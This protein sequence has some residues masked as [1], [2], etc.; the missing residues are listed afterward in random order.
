KKTVFKN[1]SLVFMGFGLLFFGM[2]LISIS[3]HHFAENP[4]LTEVFQSLRDN[5]GYSLLISVVFCAFVQSSA[6]TIGLAM[7]LATVKAIT[8]Y[9]AM[10]WVYGANIGTT[11]VAL[12]AAAGGNYIGRQVAWAHFFYKTLSVVI[13][14]PFTQIFIDFLMTFD[15]TQT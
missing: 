15:T 8:F 7:S 9:D 1:L 2:K 11:S 6:V 14:Y 12:I 10:L 13:F 4:M 5:P 3:S